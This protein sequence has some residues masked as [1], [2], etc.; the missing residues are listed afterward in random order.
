MLSGAFIL[1]EEAEGPWGEVPGREGSWSFRWKASCVVDGGKRSREN[2][3]MVERGER[4]S[5][6]AGGGIVDG[7]L[8]DLFTCRSI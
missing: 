5:W 1:A 7:L 4:R 2:R 6:M 3:E 8:E